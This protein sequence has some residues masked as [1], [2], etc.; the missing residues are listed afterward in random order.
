VRTR[1]R[2]LARQAPASMVS[3]AV[4][5][6]SLAFWE[7][8]RTLPSRPRAAVV[9]Y[10]AGDRPVSEVAT[11]LDVPEGTVRSDLARARTALVKMLE[12]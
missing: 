9:L 1:S 10:Y 12:G 8:V 4:S 7:A 6:E 2:Y 3:D 11:I 5:V